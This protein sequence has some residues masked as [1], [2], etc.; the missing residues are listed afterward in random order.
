MRSRALPRS[1][2]RTARREPQ[3]RTSEQIVDAILDAAAALVGETGNVTGITTNHVA[4]RAGVSIGS[5]YRYFPDKESIVAALDLR[6]R[7]ASGARFLSRLAE[8]ETDFAGALRQALRT[9]IEDG[10]APDVRAA[11]MRDVPA[12]WVA[13]NARQVWDQVV[14]IAASALLRIRPQLTVNEARTRVFF[15][16]HA[17]QGVTAGLL[18]WPVEGVAREDIIETTARQLEATLLAPA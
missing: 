8:F 3:C 5:L 14:Q 9:F 1:S 15:A 4:E 10:P 17:T 16:I 7:R 12:A 2:E 11:L 6:Y 13:S 18:L